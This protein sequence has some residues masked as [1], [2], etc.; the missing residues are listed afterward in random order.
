MQGKV[1]LPITAPALP[2]V[3]LS[4]LAG[5]CLLHLQPS[6]VGP[7]WTAGEL[8][9]LL[10]VALGLFVVH[11]GFRLVTGFLMGYLWTLL[12]A[13]LYLQ[14]VLPE[15][16]A[17]QDFIVEGVVQGIPEHSRDSLRFEFLIRNYPDNLA[18]PAAR[19]LRLSWYY[20][21]RQLNS[22]DRLR[23][24]VRLKPP[25]GMQN[26]G[27]FDYEKWLF[28][29]GIHATGYVRKSESTNLLAAGKFSIDRLR[30]ALQQQIR[31]I[32]EPRFQGL[33]QALTIG[34]RS[35]ISP[36]QWQ[37]LIDTG[38]SHLMAISGLHIGLV[39]GMVFFLVR[40]L[41]P[42]ALAARGSLQQVAALASLLVAGFYAL[43]AGF[44]VPTQRAFV[45]LLVI[46]LALFFRRPAFSLNT[47]ALALLAVLLI[48][49][50]APLSAGFWLSFLAV[51][52][53]HMLVTGRQPTADTRLARWLQ[54][55]R[56]QW[57]IALAMLPLT[58]I[59]FQQASLVS[60]LANLLV[61]PLVGLLVVP[62]ALLASVAGM[63]S[64]EWSV[65]LFSQVSWMLQGVMW[66]LDNLSAW[67]F[68]SHYIPG[69]NV[70]CALLALIGSLLL[71]MPRGF[72]LRYAGAVMLLPLLLYQPQRPA[73][74]EVWMTVLD[75]GQG[76]SVLLQT[77]EHDLLYDAGDKS[78]A[79]FDMGER[80]VVPFLRYRG[81][82]TL[83][84][85]IVSHADRDH[86][87]GAA[88][89][90]SRLPVRQLM[91]DVS[92]VQPLAEW[93]AFQPCQRGQG[94]HWDGVEFRVLHPDRDYSKT[95]NDSCVLQL[96]GEGYS[97]LLPG[98]IEARVERLLL[99]RDGE[100]LAADVLL[101]AHHGS[102]TSSTHAWLQRVKPSLA[103]VSAGYKN[104]FRH[105]AAKVRKRLHAMQ[106]P[107]LNTASSGAIEIRLSP[108]QGNVVT[109][110]TSWRKVAVHYWNHRF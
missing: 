60:P 100:A 86:A 88:A 21:E 12:F 9:A 76:L 19:R 57:A 64:A 92:R 5:C 95:N 30:Q 74:G 105:P 14:A 80:V 23:L 72:P 81:I 34:A 59:L 48:N 103:I 97:L 50:L 22:G 78:S 93:L 49:P 42:A 28:L 45:M 55:G 66:I 10:P 1:D 65:W 44:S 54:G 87:G 96:R 6:L 62:M 102:N 73:P 39:A 27:G 32:D 109:E 58:L 104:R 11:P 106:L 38:T 83:D 24:E 85:M 70:I 98:D 17:G 53:I 68:A 29:R 67:P 16:L 20:P 35:D 71:L 56:L 110:I 90:I 18:A 33:I 3:A 99:A 13:Q 41:S 47:L 46:L 61:I 89:V 91:G 63:I 25:H 26:P 82:E 94:W 8:V 36:Q 37:R 108:R 77:A 51:L 2:A 107:A 43:M 31:A 69:T 52:I 84:R 75:V 101:L 4:V 15:A 7:A 40:K 79:R